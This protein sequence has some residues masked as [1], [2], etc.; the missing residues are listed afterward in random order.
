MKSYFRNFLKTVCLLSLGVFLYAGGVNAAKVRKAAVAGQFYPSDR[1]QLT[2]LIEHL[3]RQAQQTKIDTPGQGVLKALI[4]PHAGYVYSGLTAAH[5][6]HLLS[7]NQFDKVILLGPDHRVGFSNGAITD[8]GAYETPLGQIKLHK[9]AAQLLQTDLFKTVPASDRGEHSLEAVLPFLQYYLKKFELVPI[10]LGRGD[11]KGMADAINTR[12][13]QK[14]LLAVS[15]DLSHFL[16]YDKAVAFDKET[17]KMISA[18]KAKK[19]LQRDNAACGVVPIAIL[20]HLA[21]LHGWHPQLLHYSN[22]GDTAGDHKR[23]VGYAAIAF[24]GGSSMNAYDQKEI[25]KTLKFRD[26]QGQAL[27]KLARQTIAA[28]LGKKT[29]LPESAVTTLQAKELKNR[30]G[31]FVTLTI[32]GQ[33]RGCIGSLNAVE[34]VVDGVKR[35]AANA[36]FGDPRFNN[37]QPSEL[38]KTDI[39]ISIL[40]EPQPLAY[41]DGA[42]LIAK[43]RPDIDGLIIRKGMASATFL[44]QVWEQLPDPE[45]FLSHLCRKAG[46]SANAWKDG[47]LEVQTYQVQYFHEQK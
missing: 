42:D 36:A 30:R 34:S 26:D 35:N 7:E 1:A 27:V 39:E 28:R 9:D 31:T 40:T 45:A 20:L 11:I 6:S 46:L 4:L 21:R 2:Q 13:D 8:S 15:S 32:D 10:V 38:D 33:L 22:S 44:P 37:L 19:L 12:L 29:T 47:K 41:K 5:A 16:S 23:V 14:T 24:Y 25:K 17:L 43:L 18:L 3:T